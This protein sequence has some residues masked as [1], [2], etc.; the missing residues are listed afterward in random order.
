MLSAA[1][2]FSPRVITLSPLQRSTIFPTVVI[3]KPGAVSALVLLILSLPCQNLPPHPA[4]PS[5]PPWAYMNLG[6]AASFPL[7]LLLT[8]CAPFHLTLLL[9][10]PFPL[11]TSSIR[12]SAPSHFTGCLLPGDLIQACVRCG[13]YQS[14]T[15]S[16]HLQI[17]AVTIMV[18]S[19][20][21][22]A[23][24]LWKQSIWDSCPNPFQCPSQIRRRWREGK[25]NTI[26]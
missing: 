17:F 18:I 11:P 20:Q 15:P 7:L 3:T 13:L 21:P 19:K 5:P 22:P 16:E 12:A 6:S 10:S 25:E 23:R 14:V 1:Q 2:P 24:G 8:A 9:L 26:K 4:P